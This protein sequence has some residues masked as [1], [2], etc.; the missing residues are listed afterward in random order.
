MD[1]IRHVNFD[2]DPQSIVYFDFEAGCQGWGDTQ[3]GVTN[4]QAVDGILSGDST[5]NNPT[6]Y[7]S[8]LSPYF[9]G[10]NYTEWQVPMKATAGTEWQLYWDYSGGTWQNDRS[11]TVP[12]IAD[13]QWHTY[14]LDMLQNS[15]WT[16]RSPA[17]MRMDPTNV[18]GAHCEIDYIRTTDAPVPGTFAMPSRLMITLDNSAFMLEGSFTD[19]YGIIWSDNQG[20]EREPHGYTGQ[21]READLDLYHYGARMYMPELGRFLQVDPAREYWNSY[22]YVGNNPVSLTD[23][24]GQDSWVFYYKIHFEGQATDEGKKLESQYSK[25]VHLIPVSSLV[26]FSKGYEQMMQDPEIQTVSMFFHS[27]A[28]ELLFDRRGE[29]GT[30]TWEA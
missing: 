8:Y 22:S 7:G 9:S 30:D 5:K 12:M 14:T 26:D 13:N 20:D 19:P 24:D 10:A 21:E 27:N 3:T 1:Y 25:P 15:E 17:I 29:N 28:Q 23:P 2:P 18:A 16:D 6:L 11:I 4:L